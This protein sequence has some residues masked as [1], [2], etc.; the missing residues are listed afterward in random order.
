MTK[1]KPNPTPPKR[2]RLT[3]RKVAEN[4]GVAALIMQIEDMFDLSDDPDVVETGKWSISY[5]P[6]KHSEEE[7]R[8]SKSES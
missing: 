5:G 2:K 6:Q 8:A 1:P 7:P 3:R 4:L